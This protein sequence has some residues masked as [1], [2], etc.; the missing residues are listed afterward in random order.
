MPARQ[1][2]AAAIA[3]LRTPAAVRDRCGAVLE[4][5]ERDALAH[6]A[7]DASGLEA[8]ARTVADLL[9]TTYPTLDI[10]LHS[11]WRHFAA[12][13][14]DRWSALAA[15]LDAAAPEELARIRID[16]AVTSVLLD[17]GAGER[18]RYRE[19]ASGATFARSEGLAVASF[20]LFAS[21]ALSATPGRRLRADAAA[22]ARIDAPRLAAAFQ[23]TDDN[24]L[25][26]LDGRAA[27]L[28]RLARAL[29]SEPELFGA[30]PRIGN[31]FDHLAGRARAG[32]LPAPDVLGALLRGLSVL[33]PEGARIDGV[34][35]GDVWRH[36]AI[37]AGDL[38]DGLVPFH[39]LA[40]WLTYSLVEPLAEAG[41]EVTELA[42]LTGLAE[43]RNGGLLVD[44]GA[45]RPKHAA[46]LAE[47][48]PVGAE[49]IV[50]WRA[51]TVALLD[52][53]AEAVRARLGV[54]AAALPLAKLLEGGTWPAGRK[55]AASLR[56]GGGPPIRI[57]SDG[58]VF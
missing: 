29:E 35:L 21:G 37:C 13:G 5:A 18:W 14:I 34:P 46:V 2:A 57:A 22:L 39:K 9:S 52:R 10:P 3:W 4:A 16:L 40:Q 41:I 25:V 26:G 30:P 1:Q 27:M 31:L 45:L 44:L 20:E 54:D 58:T 28:R 36:P 11:R 43:Y 56:P 32:R 23:V 48:H 50:E 24:P 42:E 12:G 17:A 53:L 7:V 38:T 51:L 8:A 47:V 55:L 6:F 15:R 49:V 19:P 33:W